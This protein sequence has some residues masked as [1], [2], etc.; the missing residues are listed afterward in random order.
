MTTRYILVIP[1]GVLQNSSD[2]FNVLDPDS[3][4]SATFGV[5]LYE[6]G[7]L[8]GTSPTYWASYTTLDPATYT[9]LTAYTTQQLK[10]YVDQLAIIRGRT[11]VGSVTAFPG[12]LQMQTGNPWGFIASLGLTYAY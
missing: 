5:P 2:I 12:S 1:N 4:G 8:V 3:G 11:P 10:D 9:V 7:S 6:T